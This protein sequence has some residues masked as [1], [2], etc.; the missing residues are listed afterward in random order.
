MDYRG[1][2]ARTRER[3]DTEKPWWTV[4]ENF[5]A[6]LVLYMEEELEERIFGPSDADL[7]IIEEH[8][9]TLIQL[10]QWFLASG[11][12]R[13]M[14]VG[15]IMARRWLLEMV[16][17]LGSSDFKLQAQGLE[18]LQHVRSK[19]LAKHDL[20]AFSV[21]QPNS[22]VAPRRSEVVSLAE[23]AGIPLPFG[24]FF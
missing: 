5:L 18:M 2:R 6:P 12:S 16:L 11:R 24:C 13:V 14:V 20:C 15:P 10:E 21:L 19:P 3:A 1:A 9:C 22:R 4:L 23:F 17:C 8:S 7:R